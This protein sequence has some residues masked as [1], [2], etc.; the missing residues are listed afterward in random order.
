MILN[1]TLSLTASLALLCVMPSMAGAQ[2]RRQTE[3]GTLRCDVSAGIGA[4]VT[5]TRSMRCTLES[6]NRLPE[7]YVGRIRR[8]GLDIGATAGGVLVWGVLS[9]SSDIRPGALRGE[10]VG[11][12]ADASAGAGLGANALVGGS[13][14]TISLQPLSVQGQVGLNIA[15][16]VAR[17]SL[18]PVRLRR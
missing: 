13:R 6:I 7:A 1:R 15:A 10:Y 5:S 16:G 4:I 8:F 2:E 3:V 17:L 18:T 9:S 12:S 14:R 11:A